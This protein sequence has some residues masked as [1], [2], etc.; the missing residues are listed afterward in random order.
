MSTVLGRTGLAVSLFLA[1]WG[2]VVANASYAW[3]TRNGGDDS[4]GAN[5]LALA[6]AHPTIL[7][8]AILAA[9][10]GSLLMVPAAIGAMRLIGD[11]AA[12]LGLVGGVLVAAGYICYFSVAQSSFTALAMVDNDGPRAEYAAVLDASQQNPLV[13]WVFLLF[14]L[15]NL[16]GTF[17]LGLALWRSHR[18]PVWAA[19]AVMAWPPLHVIGLIV[20]SEWFEVTGALLETVGF[21]VVGARLLGRSPEVVA[22]TPALAT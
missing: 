2:F 13:I 1:P 10:L 4:T 8:A 12:R 17:L 15:G 14:V 5:A 19:A 16:V 11:R 22:A 6:A 20:G 9:M 3:A 18:V 21:A 7:S